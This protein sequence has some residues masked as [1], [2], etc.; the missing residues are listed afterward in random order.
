LGFHACCGG[1]NA[2]SKALNMGIDVSDSVK[3]HRC[4][5]DSIRRV[6]IA[7]SNGSLW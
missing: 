3:P 4:N 5:Q 2:I 7:E 1:V 6:M